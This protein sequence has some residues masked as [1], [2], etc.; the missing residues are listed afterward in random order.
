MIIYPRQGQSAEQQALDF[1]EC[2]SWAVSEADFDPEIPPEGPPD[3]L[4]SEKSADYLR[5]ISACLDAR[6]YTLK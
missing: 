2:H 3:D 1:D 6:G 4:S 5:A